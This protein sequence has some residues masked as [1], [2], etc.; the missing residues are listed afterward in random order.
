MS[1][2]KTIKIAQHIFM[3]VSKQVNEEVIRDTNAY[4]CMYV[5]MVELLSSI[6]PLKAVTNVCSRRQTPKINQG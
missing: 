6:H 2:T 3:C 5:C 4:V 1:C